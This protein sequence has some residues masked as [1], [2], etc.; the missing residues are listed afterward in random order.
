[1]ILDQATVKRQAW[2]SI[3]AKSNSGILQELWSNSGLERSFQVLRKPE[4][5]LVMVRGRMGGT[6][7]PFN[8]GE[9]TV[10]RCSVRSETGK[11]GHSYILGRDHTHAQVAAEIDAVLQDESTR[12]HILKAIITPLQ[13]IAQEKRDINKRKTAATKV[14]FFTVVRG[15]D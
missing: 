13:Q 2:M 7:A 15:E 6:G 10:T 12:P 5:G 14:D 11:V 1:M 4:T 8:T 3:L 9:A